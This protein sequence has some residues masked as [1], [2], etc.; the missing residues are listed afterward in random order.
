MRWSWAEHL[1]FAIT[2]TTTT[3]NNNNARSHTQ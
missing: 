1:N 3:T 2:T